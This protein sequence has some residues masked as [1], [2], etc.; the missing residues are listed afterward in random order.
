MRNRFRPLRDLIP[1]RLSMN[2]KRRKRGRLWS[3]SF[4]EF[5]SVE[6]GVLSMDF[7]FPR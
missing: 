1:S 7:F 3:F 2:N 4:P 6:K 5:R